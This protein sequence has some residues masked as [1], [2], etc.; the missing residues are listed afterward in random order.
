MSANG[1]PYLKWTLDTPQDL[2]KW[3]CT[4][5]CRYQCML[6]EESSRDS[7]AQPI[8]YH[9]KWPFLRILNIQV[10]WTILTS[11]W[12]LA[13]LRTIIFHRSVTNRM[14][15]CIACWGLEG[16]KIFLNSMALCVRRESISVVFD[17]FLFCIEYHWCLTTCGACVEVVLRFERRA[18]YFGSL[19][20][21]LMAC[22]N[23]FGPQGNNTEF[24]RVDLH[25]TSRH[26][27]KLTG[28]GRCC[29]QNNKLLTKIPFESKDKS[30]RLGTC[31]VVTF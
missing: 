21:K 20:A 8:K 23:E 3:D 1:K 31:K 19:R 6:R 30:T 22:Q 25:T 5:E 10:H 27:P 2:L 18:T 24:S 13:R 9:G 16:L 12:W 15:C 4:G 17:W 28:H 7:S 14:C 26:G 29:M 11:A